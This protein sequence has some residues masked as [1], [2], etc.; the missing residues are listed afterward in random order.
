VGQLLT[1]QQQVSAAKALSSVRRGCADQRTSSRPIFERG[2][3]AGDEERYVDHSCYDLAEHV[4]DNQP[5]PDWIPV[6][7]GSGAAPNV[8]SPR[9]TRFGLWEGSGAVPRPA[10]YR[11]DSRSR[12]DGLQHADV[13]RLVQWR[14]R[15]PAT[16]RA[17]ARRSP[18]LVAKSSRPTCLRP[19]LGHLHRFSGVGSR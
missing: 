16:G 17:R 7:D 11:P 5:T 14:N 1:L 18:G 13:R 12:L 10:A 8:L 3:R 6:R 2:Q 9:R 19:E 4:L 15:A